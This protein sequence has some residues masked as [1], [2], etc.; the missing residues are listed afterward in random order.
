MPDATRDAFRDEPE[1]TEEMTSAVE[2]ADNQ[3]IILPFNPEVTSKRNDV[4]ENVTEMLTLLGDQ[5]ATG[6]TE[7]ADAMAEDILVRMQAA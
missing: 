1:V 6:N 4:A 3:P 7:D 2:S 5:A